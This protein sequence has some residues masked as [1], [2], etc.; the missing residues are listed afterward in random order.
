MISLPKLTILLILSLGSLSSAQFP[1]PVAPTPK[2]IKA[3]RLLDVRAGKYLLDAGV[4]TEGEKISKIGPWTEIKSQSPADAVLI[5]LNNATLLPGLI[6]C[7]AHLLSSGEIH[8]DSAGAA[9]LSL[10]QA[11][12][13]LRALMG[14]RHA[15][16]ALEAGVT[17]ARIL[18]HSGIDCDISLRDAI[19]AGWLA[20]PRLQV[21]VRKISAAG[22]IIPATIEHLNQS[23]LIPVSGP[24]EARRAVR[25]NAGMGADVIKI[26]VDA[27][28]SR[29]GLK[30]YMPLEDAKAIVT[31][32]HRLGL[33][34]AAHAE[35]TAAVQIAIDAG[36]DSIEHAWSITDDQ[37]RKLKELGIYLCATDLLVSVSP[38]D[39]LQRAIK[40]GVKIAFGSDMWIA[41]AGKN[42][43]EAS[44]LALELLGKEGMSNIEIIRA[45]TTIAAE[46]M[47]WSDRVGELAPGKFA[48]IIAVAGD[49]L[50]DLSLVQRIQ[51]VMKGAVVIKNS[52]SGT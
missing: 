43:G 18:G 38:K 28:A 29:S 50:E 7:H 3:G 48:D 6:D 45:S 10:T 36:V 14:S 16:E 11:S 8:R 41:W 19:N 39:R 22:A 51:F 12:D 24:D 47:G 52:F 17:S 13:S 33:K 27:G 42:R 46:L 1:R 49:P 15:R 35:D 5:D 30:R 40:I 31:D 23:E 34:V 9:K 2:L 25:E 4:L 26:V 20:G 44:L 21:A 32:A 37:L